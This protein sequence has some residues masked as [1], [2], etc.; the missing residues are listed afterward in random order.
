MNGQTPRSV[1]I[2]RAWIRISGW[3]WSCIRAGAWACGMGAGPAHLAWGILSRAPW[4]GAQELGGCAAFSQR[5][6][7]VAPCMEQAGT[8][9]TPHP[10]QVPGMPQVPAV[11]PGRRRGARTGGP[12]AARPT[13]LCFKRETG[14]APMLPVARWASPVPATAGP[15]RRRTTREDSGDTRVHP[16]PP[17][18]LDATSRPQAQSLRRDRPRACLPPAATPPSATSPLRRT[19]S[20]RRTPFALSPRCSWGVP[21]TWR[22]TN[23]TA[24]PG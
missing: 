2:S 24:L 10:E 21:R 14:P 13:R 7:L 17:L 5:I 20:A 1:P 4:Q 12:R 15:A 11:L 3:C 9:A 22:T 19:M 8:L 16:H 18:A 6:A 23:W